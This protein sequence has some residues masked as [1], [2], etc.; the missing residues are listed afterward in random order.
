MAASVLVV[1]PLVVLFFVFQ[2]YFLRG[3]SLGGFK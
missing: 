1:V 3:I 2:R